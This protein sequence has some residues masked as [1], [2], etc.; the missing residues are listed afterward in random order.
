MKKAWWRRDAG[1]LVA[2]V[3]PAATAGAAAGGAAG[4]AVAELVEAVSA[5]GAGKTV[6]VALVAGLPSS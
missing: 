5:G 1:A 4:G 6:T 2:A 3:V